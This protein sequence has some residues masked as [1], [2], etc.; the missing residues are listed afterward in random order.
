MN[1]CEGFTARCP[2]KMVNVVVNV[3]SKMDEKVNVKMFLHP[4]FVLVDVGARG[5]L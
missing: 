2:D 5:D 4:R 3:L 1:H